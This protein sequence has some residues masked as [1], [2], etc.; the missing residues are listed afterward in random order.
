M[1]KL[2]LITMIALLA[3]APLAG[4]GVSA[5]DYDKVVSDLAAAQ[6]QI[7][8]LETDLASAQDEL[9]Q[10]EDE[11]A[12]LQSKLDDTNT[13]Y[14]A[15]Q[16]EYDDL[17]TL[18][19]QVVAALESARVYEQIIVELISPAITGDDL[20]APETISRVKELVDFTNDETLK[21]KFADWESAPYSRTRAAEL[22]VHALLK[23]EQLVF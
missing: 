16:A 3:A 12:T 9:S 1:K 6:T 4:C 14:E 19:D 7:Q 20:T 5:E 10:L 22:L 2:F 11:N 8:E 18:V 17:K 13:A 21:E 23:L 15:L